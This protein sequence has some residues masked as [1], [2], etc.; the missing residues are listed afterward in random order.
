MLSRLRRGVL[1]VSRAKY[2][3]GFGI[4][5][6]WAYRF[7][8]YV[9]NEH[10]PYYAYD[11]LRRQYPRLSLRERKLCEL[12]LRIANYQQATEAELL[13]DVSDATRAYLRAGCRQMRLVPGDGMAGRPFA[14]AIVAFG[15]Q[16]E[17]QALG[18]MERATDH[19]VLI[20]EGIH[21]N[22]AARQ[23]WMRMRQ[24]ERVRVS[25]DLY[26][27]GLLF[28]DKKKHKCNYKINF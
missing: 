2:C 23:G 7:V 24:D 1:W 8:R 9:I 21:R 6:P 27:C 17:T 10:W 25:F 14:L 22:A 18:L 4:Q 20:V 19:S 15:Q 3:R 16:M 12:Y 28:F 11:D 13:G 26:Y 5:S